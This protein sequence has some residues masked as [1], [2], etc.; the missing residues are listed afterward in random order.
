VD[1]FIEESLKSKPEFY[2]WLGD[3]SPH[4]PWSTNKADHM[5]GTIETTKL[6]AKHP[7]Y[8][9][10]GKMYPIIGNHEG[11]P[12]DQFNVEGDEHR[13]ILSELADLWKVWFTKECKDKV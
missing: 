10:V 12:C 11:M 5:W 4:D 1:S 8:M 7:E 6:F 9:Q 2:I 3:N 13:W